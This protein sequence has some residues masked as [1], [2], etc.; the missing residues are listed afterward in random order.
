MTKHC[1]SSLSSHCLHVKKLVGAKLPEVEKEA[2]KIKEVF[3]RYV[4]FPKGQRL[5]RFVVDLLPS[6][7][8]KLFFLQVKFFM[9]ENKYMSDYGRLKKLKLNRG[10]NLKEEECEGIFCEKLNDTPALK[11]ILS[12]LLIGG[13]LNKKW[14]KTGIYLIPSKLIMDYSK[15]LS[16]YEYFR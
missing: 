12:Y 2:Q 5:T 14:A 1:V 4:F 11:E 10:L 15:A 13:Y 16:E 9:S 6:M 7:E 3:E 8:G